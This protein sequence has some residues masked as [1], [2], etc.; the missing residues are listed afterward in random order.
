MTVSFRVVT[1]LPVPPERAFALSLDIGAHE[2]SM[3]ASGE[4]A[5]AGTT[6]GTIGLGE[7]VTWRARHFG[8]VWRMTSRITALEG[9]RRF[10]DEQVRGPFARFHHEHRFEPSAGGT[11]MVDTITFRAPLGP[12]G[13]VAEVLALARYMPQ[14]IADRNASLAAEL[15]ADSDGD[16]GA[17]SSPNAS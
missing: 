14:L 5:V 17:A 16:Q 7:T 12:L 9:P 3:A 1:D 4:R 13:R 11:R 2:R 8:I 10:V 6:A 15:R